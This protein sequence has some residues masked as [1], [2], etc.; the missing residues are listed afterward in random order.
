ML[1]G[2][3]HLCL[4]QSKAQFWQRPFAPLRVTGFLFS[5]FYMFA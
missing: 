1:S 5:A 3:K 4:T 2:A